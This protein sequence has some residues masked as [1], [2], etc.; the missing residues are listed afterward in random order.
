MGDMTDMVLNH[1]SVDAL[2]PCLNDCLEPERLETEGACFLETSVNLMSNQP[3]Q[4]QIPTENIGNMSLD[5]LDSQLESLCAS[6]CPEDC[7]LWE[8]CL[9]ESNLE[10]VCAPADVE[11]AEFQPIPAHSGLK[12]VHFK[13][14]FS[15]LKCLT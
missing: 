8:D 5:D 13:T 7:A 1:V 12:C 11:E 10:F 14:K 15:K 2:S 3:S 6:A 4:F 9:K